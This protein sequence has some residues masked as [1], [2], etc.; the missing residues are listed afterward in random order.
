MN[1]RRIEL[2]F[3]NWRWFDLKRTMTPDALAAFLNAYGLR[4]RANPTASRQGIPFATNDYQFQSYKAFYP[5]PND[6]R[7]I[8]KDLI[9]NTGY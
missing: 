6:E 9:Q 8:N 7:I 1:E 2:A 5:I 3:E 4:E